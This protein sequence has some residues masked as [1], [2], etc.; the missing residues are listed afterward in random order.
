MT[1][2]TARP[3][4]TPVSAERQSRAVPAARTIVSAST[5]STAQAKKTAMNRAVPLIG[6]PYGVLA[7]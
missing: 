1:V 4:A 5:A 6:T 3:A 2:R 7:R